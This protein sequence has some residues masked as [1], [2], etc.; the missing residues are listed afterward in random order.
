MRPFSKA[1]AA[2]VRRPARLLLVG[3]GTAAVWASAALLPPVLAALG[4]V[5]AVG[6]VYSCGG[7]LPGLKHLRPHNRRVRRL[8]GS[9]GLAVLLA[10][11][12]P[13]AD[14]SAQEAAAPA[15]EAATEEPG[16][17]DGFLGTLSGLGSQIGDAA[18][19]AAD[20]VIK[21]VTLADAK[22]KVTEAAVE[23][24][25]GECFVCTVTDYLVVAGDAVTKTTFQ[26][27][28]GALS[29]ALGTLIALAV[30]VLF[31]RIVIGQADLRDLGRFVLR[32]GFFGAI[33]TLVLSPA[34]HGVVFDWIYEPV[35][36]AV[37]GAAVAIVGLLAP[38]GS[39][40][41]PLATTSIDLGGLAPLSGG[42]RGAISAFS[43]ELQR[44]FGVP[45]A[46]GV[47]GIASAIFELFW[48]IS[49]P[50]ALPRVAMSLAIVAVYFPLFLAG[51]LF[52]ITPVFAVMSVTALSPILLLGLLFGVAK[53]WLKSGASI[54]LETFLYCVLGALVIGVVR[55]GI[56][57]TLT[58]TLGGP[59]HVEG[60]FVE[61]FGRMLGQDDEAGALT[62]PAFAAPWLFL[63][64]G[65]FAKSMLSAVKSYASAI[66]GVSSDLSSASGALGQ[67]V[68]TVIGTTAAVAALAGKAGAAAATGGVGGVA[69]AA[70]GIRS[71]RKKM[72]LGGE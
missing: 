65:Y 45:L 57:F 48:P 29:T 38:V 7:L 12:L 41:A 1:F 51:S 46:I 17:F 72:S 52:L 31:V 4:V 11:S 71:L 40:S 2:L 30:L 36:S 6:L 55:A 54:L 27:L 70:A 44:T 19:D 58:S 34:G 43:F 67:T 32:Y 42:A 22:G 20:D 14:A 60:D 5:L 49:A 66:A 24:I 39:A 35:L 50:L 10:L 59:V 25:A 16:F 61:T 3:F 18:A 8:L 62:N 68:G 28:A 53:P 15:A 23:F 33:L 63:L 26:H 13:V 56:M 9:A 21:K 37:S 69:G 47:A 64:F